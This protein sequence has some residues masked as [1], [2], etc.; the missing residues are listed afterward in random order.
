VDIANHTYKFGQQMSSLDRAVRRY[1]RRQNEL[2]NDYAELGAAY[3][4]FAQTEQA[5]GLGVPLAR[6]GD[7]VDMVFLSTRYLV[8]A[9]WHRHTHGHTHTRRHMQKCVWEDGRRGERERERERERD[10]THTHTHAHTDTRGLTGADGGPR[11]TS[12]GQVGAP[13]LL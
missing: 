8:R 3:Q 1:T 11:L 12:P 4:A 2:A 13:P 7:A 9:S 10:L 6:V 5:Q